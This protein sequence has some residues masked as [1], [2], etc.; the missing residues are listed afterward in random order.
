MFVDA[1]FTIYFWKF[2]CLNITKVHGAFKQ[3]RFLHLTFHIPGVAWGRNYKWF[4][5]FWGALFRISGLPSVRLY[6]PVSSQYSEIDLCCLSCSCLSAHLIRLV[7]RGCIQKFLDWPP[8]ARTAN[9]TALCYWV[10]LYRYFVSQHSEFCHHN[11]LYCLLFISLSTQ[12]G[13]F[14]IHLPSEAGS[15]ELRIICL[16]V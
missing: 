9:G 13:N 4:L 15:L 11:P 2:R 5:Y 10:Q 1:M 6:G 12:S 16:A 3:N 14:W 8:A 7:I